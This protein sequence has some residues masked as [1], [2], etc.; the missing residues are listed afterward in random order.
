MDLLIKDL[1][2]EMTVA[3]TEEKDAQAEYESMMKHSSE[4]RAL[5]SKAITEKAG[6]KAGLEEDLEGHKQAGANANAELSATAQFIGELHAE[7][8][9]LIKYADARKAAR[10]GEIESL[11]SA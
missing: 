1:D 2:K 10:N 9:W 8:D 4:K 6:A 5:D 11:G 3:S 7:C